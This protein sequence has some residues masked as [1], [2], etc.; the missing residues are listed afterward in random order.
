[1]AYNQD[2]DDRLELIGTVV[3][4]NKGIFKI[5]IEE[6]YIVT[7]KI[8]GRLKMREIKVIVGDLVECQVSPYD[9]NTGRITRRLKAQ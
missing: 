2:R 3:S 7:A 6:N 1:M 5:Q 9:L 4:S 8:S